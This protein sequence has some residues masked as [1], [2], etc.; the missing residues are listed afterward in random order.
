MSIQTPLPVE[1]PAFIL[2]AE[3]NKL[4][5]PGLLHRIKAFFIDFAVLLSAFLISTNI[6][7]LAGEMPAWIRGA[8]LIFMFCLYDPFMI[9]FAG[10]TLGHKAI[11]LKIKR[12]NRREKNLNLGFA[13]LRF[14]IKNILGWISFFTVTTDP[15]KRSIHDLSVGSIVL[16]KD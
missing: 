13:F 16:F 9:A 11:G 12:Y 15:R 7:E 8:V 14:F 4:Q 5:F 10:G 1:N 6:I 3:Y 2:E